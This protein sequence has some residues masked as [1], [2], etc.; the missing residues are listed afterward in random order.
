MNK[1]LHLP[2]KAQWYE[3]IES[4]VK[5]EEY[6]EIKSYWVQRLCSCT[7]ECCNGHFSEGKYNCIFKCKAFYGHMNWYID[8]KRIAPYTRVKF[9]Y[10]YT[11]RT[12]TFEIE[13]ITIGNGNPEWGA[14]D[15]EVFII[16]LGRR[17]A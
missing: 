3:M 6:R 8:G 7:H 2:L 12:M 14:P 9:S 16:K 10:G 13:S 15:K 4:E 17:V 5:T 1:T 11:R